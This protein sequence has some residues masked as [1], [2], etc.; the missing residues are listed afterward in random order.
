[1]VCVQGDEFTVVLLVLR[2]IC[3]NGDCKTSLNS[4]TVRKGKKSSLAIPLSQVT[5]ANFL[6]EVWAKQNG[7]LPKAY[8]EDDAGWGLK[9]LDILI[10]PFPFF[11]GTITKFVVN[12]RI[13][14]AASAYEV[15][16]LGAEIGGRMMSIHKAPTNTYRGGGAVQ[17]ECS[18]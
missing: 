18:S 13:G 10:K 16:I 8:G 5:G 6:A 9:D 11:A 1:V 15:S 17:L 4:D 14:S 12:E 2:Q 7:V 3:S